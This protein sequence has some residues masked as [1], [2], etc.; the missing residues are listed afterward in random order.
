MTADPDKVWPHGRVPY[1]FDPTMGRFI[2]HL[3]FLFRQYLT[4]SFINY[5]ST[6]DV[7][8][9]VKGTSVFT[10][11]CENNVCVYMYVRYYV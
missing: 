3:A 6:Y 2:Y 5:N 7:L 8:M 11:K 10:A 9:I 4:L 1:K